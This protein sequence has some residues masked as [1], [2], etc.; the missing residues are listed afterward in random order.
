MR[1]ADSALSQD[2]AD[3]LQLNKAQAAE[4]RRRVCEMRDPTRYAV[5]SPLT[6]RFNFYYQVS[7]GIPMLNQVAEGMALK[8]RAEAEAVARVAERRQKKRSVRS[9]QV[10]A[11]KNTRTGIRILSTYLNDNSQYAAGVNFQ[12]VI[13]PEPFMV[14][15]ILK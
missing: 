13:I 14:A 8:N 6:L 2:R 9:L 12:F 11:V 7:D 5:V 10:I 4:I 1:R 15:L 3:G